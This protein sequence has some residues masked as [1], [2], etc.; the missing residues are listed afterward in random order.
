MGL[1]GNGR[2]ERVRWRDERTGDTETHGIRHV[3]MMTGAI[4][5]TRWLAG[6]IA[7]DGKGFVHTGPDLSPEELA[8]A[9]GRTPVHRV[10]SRRTGPESLRLATCAGGNVKHVASAVGEG[11][12][13]VA[14]VHQVLRP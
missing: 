7:L 13:A 10:C 14:L 6:C 4:P 2:L 9:N 8:V 1:E 3:C 12:I 11:S 5:N